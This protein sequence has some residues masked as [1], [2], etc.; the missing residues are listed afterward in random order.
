MVEGQDVSILR[1]Q[2]QLILPPVIVVGLLVFAWNLCGDG[3]NDVR[4]TRTR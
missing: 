4:N 3:L 2:P 1:N